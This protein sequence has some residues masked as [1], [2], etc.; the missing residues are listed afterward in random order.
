MKDFTPHIFISLGESNRRFTLR[1]TALQTTTDD[2]QHVISIHIQNLSSKLDRSLQMAWD[3]A[4]EY[5]VEFKYDPER[6]LFPADLDEFNRIK[7]EKKK[8]ARQEKI[9]AAERQKSAYEEEKAARLQ[10]KIKQL[11]EGTYPFGKHLDEKIEDHPGYAAW[12]VSKKDEFEKGSILHHAA[13]IIETNFKHVL[14]A[15]TTESYV[16][17]HRPEKVSTRI[18]IKGKV[19]QVMSFPGYYGY[20]YWVFIKDENGLCVIA[21]GSW[22]AEKG[23][24][25]NITAH[26]KAKEVYKGQDQTIVNRVKVS[27]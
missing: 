13:N 19:Q 25:V 15:K 11:E 23:D 17:G 7:K 4:K 10:A 6:D 8:A 16:P 24:E 14:E 26:L 20:S 18:H 27:Q 9:D 2:R 22:H 3:Y 21:K 5:D 12:L 1:K